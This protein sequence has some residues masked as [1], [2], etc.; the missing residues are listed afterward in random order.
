MIA[1]LALLLGS[2]AHATTPSN[3]ASNW[4]EEAAAVDLFFIQLWRFRIK[5][6]SFEPN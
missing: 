4:L 2:M 5:Q 1:I 3:A 6:M